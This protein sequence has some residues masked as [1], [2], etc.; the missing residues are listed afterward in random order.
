MKAEDKEEE[1]AEAEEE[2]Q[3]VMCLFVWW[4]FVGSVEIFVFSPQG[5]GMMVFGFSFDLFGFRE[6]RFECSGHGIW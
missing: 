5:M 3:H 1:E 6:G 4:D 2:E